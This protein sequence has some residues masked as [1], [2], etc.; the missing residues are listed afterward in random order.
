MFW[1]YEQGRTSV[2]ITQNKKYIHYQKKLLSCT[3]PCCCV[4][5][6]KYLP[7]PFFLHLENCM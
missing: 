4:G 1:M 2:G 7:P 5:S 6:L 3:F